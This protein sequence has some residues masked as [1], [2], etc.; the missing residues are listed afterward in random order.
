MRFWRAAAQL[1]HAERL[2]AAGRL[3]EAAPLLAESRATFAE[4]EASPWL[5]RAD[6]IAERA[7]AEAVS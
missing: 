1:E 5:A 2:A 6:V 4:L 3:A 7:S